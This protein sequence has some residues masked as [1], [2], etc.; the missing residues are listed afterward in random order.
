MTTTISTVRQGNRNIPVEMYVTN[1]S[2]CDVWLD[3]CA[4]KFMK[5]TND[6]SSYYTVKVKSPR[7]LIIPR[8]S[9]NVKVEFLVDV[10]T[11][12]KVEY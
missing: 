11:T 4:L 10:S 6:V 12:G 8:N 7:A 1:T 3:K 5:D 9:S 2:S